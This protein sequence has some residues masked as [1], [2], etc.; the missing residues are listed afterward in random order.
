MVYNTNELH[1]KDFADLKSSIFKV[2]FITEREDL[3]RSITLELMLRVTKLYIRKNHSHYSIY[4]FFST[5]GN[6]APRGHL[7]MC[8]DALVITTWSGGY[9]DTGIELVE[10]CW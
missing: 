7:A 5:R 9:S 4:Q 6:S 8:R 10:G 3:R 1:K 2:E